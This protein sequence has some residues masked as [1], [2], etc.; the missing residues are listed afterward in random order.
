MAT[1]AMADLSLGSAPKIKSKSKKPA[2]V[3]DSWEDED[4]ESDE[5]EPVPSS[6]SLGK[7]T[8]IDG[9]GFAAPPP[10]PSSPS[11]SSGNPPWQS[12]A[13]S[14]VSS[15]SPLSS[16]A[17]PASDTTSRRPEKTDAVARRMI[18]SALGVRAPKP[19]EEQ[20]AY[21]RSVRESERKRREAERE[22]EKKRLQEA[23]KARAAIW[24]D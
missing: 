11:Y 23:E 5:G 14:T 6:P 18:A 2:P 1:Q 3:L 15:P 8:K 12:M 20:K 17:S 9:S 24:E 16:P 22:A 4:V 10:T 21:D 7:E 19:T 13:S